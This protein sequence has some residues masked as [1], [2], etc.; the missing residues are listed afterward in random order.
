MP[1]S[2]VRYSNSRPIS[3]Q[4][5]SETFPDERVLIF[6]PVLEQRGSD[7]LG[8]RFRRL[9]ISLRDADAIFFRGSTLWA[10]NSSEALHAVVDGDPI[11]RDLTKGVLIGLLHVTG[12]SDLQPAI[13]V[14]ILRFGS[15]SRLNTLN[16]LEILR[17]E[18]IA[19]F[20]YCGD[21]LLS[22]G[23]FSLP[24]GLHAEKFLSI[25]RLLGD[26]VTVSRIADWF[27]DDLAGVRGILTDQPSML[28]LAFALQ[29]LSSMLFHYL[30]P[31]HVLEEYPAD[32]KTLADAI[33]LLS[34]DLGEPQRLVFLL[35]VS[36]SGR[37]LQ[38]WRSAAPPNSAIHLIFSTTLD[39][40][41]A[42]GAECLL[43]IA[44]P[45]HTLTLQGKCDLCY[46]QIPL[47]RINPKTFEPESQ[48]VLPYVPIPASRD[49]LTQHARFWGIV[50]EMDAVKLHYDDEEH[51]RH[52]P[53][54]L[55]IQRLLAHDEFRA[56]CL[57]TLHNL[58]I[59]KQL[60][61][62]PDLVLVPHH[63][64]S[65]VIGDLIREAFP[66]TS[67]EILPKGTI[68]I[69][70][71]LRPR[72]ASKQYI[73]VA[74]DAII[75]ARTIY[76]LKLQLYSIVKNFERSVAI[77]FFAAVARPTNSRHMTWLKNRLID[78]TGSHLHRAYELYLP[79]PDEFECPLC[80]ERRK[81]E[82][83][84]NRLS[85]GARE[86]A[87]ERLLSLRGHSI[88]DPLVGTNRSVVGSFMAENANG[89]Q[90]TSRRRTIFAATQAA[91][92]A[93]RDEVKVRERKRELSKIDSSDILSKYYDPELL[94]GFFR[95]IGR[96]YLAWPSR[97]EEVE[98][99]LTVLTSNAD[100]KE[101]LVELGWAVF[102]GRLP[103][104]PILEKLYEFGNDPCIQM[105][106]ELIEFN[107]LGK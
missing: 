72:I 105:T 88:D 30:P 4:Y 107:I 23:H 46:D 28:P 53:I 40:E 29:A 89:T 103:V 55:D 38:Y 34:E 2:Y 70:E 101:L 31:I 67:V 97:P 62:M 65:E 96:S 33:H 17:K 78:G 92:M 82:R 80:D 45:Q 25:K 95:T 39:V 41:T 91:A 60:G 94:A 49:R 43:D 9:D 13:K 84:I 69:P 24:S 37:L 54:Y 7:L 64:T 85:D 83:Y 98:E 42:H 71:S 68:R 21:A 1:I 57:E 15:D 99:Q 75:T 50:D 48:D 90:K 81:L 11:I 36:H 106:R 12:I 20:L 100:S 93:M 86:F 27:I 32:L 3:F 76:D 63:S 58:R 61:R 16:W 51:H 22:D 87:N 10:L 35:S 6:D 52:H 102:L 26:A 19:A 73:L 8:D 79:S 56:M 5:E 18:E 66:E 74:D 77:D 59:V 44:I 104:H 47:R 14:E